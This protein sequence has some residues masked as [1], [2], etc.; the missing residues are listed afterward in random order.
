MNNVLGNLGGNDSKKVWNL[1]KEVGN[2]LKFNKI[3]VSN[4]EDKNGAKLTEKKYVNT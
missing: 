2:I 3:I 4:I 1:L